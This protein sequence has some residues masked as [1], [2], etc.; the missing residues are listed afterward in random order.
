MSETY[1]IDLEKGEEDMTRK[2]K[3]LDAFVKSEKRKW[4]ID[5]EGNIAPRKIE[6]MSLMS[7][8]SKN[9]QQTTI[10]VWEPA[11]R[12]SQTLRTYNI[13]TYSMYFPMEVRN[14]LVE[15][16]EEESQ[17]TG[18]SSTAQTDFVDSTATNVINQ[19]F[20]TVNTVV[21]RH[22]VGK[23]AQTLNE[24]ERD[25]AC[26]YEKPVRYLL[27]TTEKVVNANRPHRYAA[28]IG[29]IAPHTECLYRTN[30][31]PALVTVQVGSALDW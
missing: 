3:K 22:G 9:G 5:S 1:V 14:F 30:G 11:D 4:Q 16:F 24:I 13:L 26:G 8:G 18:L 6:D 21:R 31:A 12:R 7:A 15:E 17:K 2:R 28:T 20:G 27:R 29:P 10:F 19:D 23:I 25:D